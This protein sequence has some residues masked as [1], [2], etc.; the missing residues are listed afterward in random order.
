MKRFALGFV[1]LVI[2]TIFSPYYPDS[3]YLTDEYEVSMTN[4]PDVLAVRA[5]CWCL[6]HRLKWKTVSFSTGS[7]LLVSLCVHSPLGESH[8]VQ[9]CQLLGYSSKY[10]LSIFTFV[11]DGKRQLSICFLKVNV[12]LSHIKPHLAQHSPLEIISSETTQPCKS[13]HSLPCAW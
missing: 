5:P 8:F 9:I 6:S 11:H 4:S 12:Y 3:Y 2:Y 7:A 13:F 1:C 10:S